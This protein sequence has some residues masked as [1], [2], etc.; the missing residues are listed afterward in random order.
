M[1]QE[2]CV[3]KLLIL[4]ILYLVLFVIN[5]KLKNICGKVASKDP[6]MMKYCF[7][8]YGSRSL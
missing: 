7:D 8:R 1:R 4:D 6:F 2:K 5:V 3:L